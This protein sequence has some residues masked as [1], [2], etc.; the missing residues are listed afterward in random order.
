MFYLE[1]VSLSAMTFRIW[2]TSKSS[3]FAKS[4]FEGAAL[5]GW[6]T[7]ATDA[8]VSTCL[9]GPAFRASSTSARIILEFGPEP[10][11]FA[12]SKPFSSAVFFARG[13][14]KILSPDEVCGLEPVWTCAGSEVYAY[15]EAVWGAEAVL[16]AGDQSARA[17]ISFSSKARMQRGEPSLTSFAPSG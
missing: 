14:I 8:L 13:L 10:E 9:T 6:A 17:G 1:N 11:I 15:D 16:P 5:T 7:A 3:K 2:L 4:T 12:I